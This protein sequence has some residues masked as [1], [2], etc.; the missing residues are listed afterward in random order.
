MSLVYFEVLTYLKSLEVKLPARAAIIS[1]V[2]SIE[3]GMIIAI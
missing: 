1:S 2:F 3:C